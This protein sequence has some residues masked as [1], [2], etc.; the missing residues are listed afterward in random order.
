MKRSIFQIHFVSDHNSERRIFLDN[1][2]DDY[3][4][5]IGETEDEPDK[6]KNKKHSKIE[7]ILTEER[8]NCD[9][10]DRTFMWKKYGDD[11]SKTFH[12]QIAWA[13]SSFKRSKEKEETE[14]GTDESKSDM[15][16]NDSSV[17]NINVILMKSPTGKIFR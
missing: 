6:A 9:P 8:K 3:Y 2:D 15:N 12:G 1:D 7:D 5:K 13:R 11:I 4:K 10:S 14:K 17:M 16:N